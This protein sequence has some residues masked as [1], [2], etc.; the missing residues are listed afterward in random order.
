MESESM[1]EGAL[2]RGTKDKHVVINMKEEFLY[3]VF[4]YKKNYLYFIV[5]KY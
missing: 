5:K 2:K 3:I 4:Y 1:F